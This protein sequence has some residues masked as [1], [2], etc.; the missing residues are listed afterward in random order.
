MQIKAALELVIPDLDTFALR[1]N[2]PLPPNYNFDAN[3]SPFTVIAPNGQE[4]L[5]QV[6]TVTRNAIGTPTIVQVLATCPRGSLVIGSKQQFLIVE[7]TQPRTVLQV[8]P[9][10]KNLIL[11]HGNLRLRASDVFGNKYEQSISFSKRAATPGR[12]RTLAVGPVS[13]TTEVARRLESTGSGT[14]LPYFGGFQAVITYQN[15]NT[16]VVSLELC[17]H[18]AMVPNPLADLYFTTLE[19]VMPNNWNAI[20]EWPEPFMDTSRI[21]GNDRILPLIKPLSNGNKHLL[22]QRDQ[23]EWRLYLYT[24]GQE[25]AANEVAQHKSWGVCVDGQQAGQRYWNWHNPITARYQTQNCIVPIVKVADLENRVKI[26]KDNLFLQLQNGLSYPDEGGGDGQLGYRNP[27]GVAYGGMTGGLGINEFDG[28]ATLSSRS[29][30]GLL[31]H[32]MLARRYGDRQRGGWIFDI[33]GIISLEKYLDADHSVPWSLYDFAFLAMSWPFQNQHNDRPFGFD[34]VDKT[35]VNFVNV[36]A[37]NPDYEV[38]ARA[39]VAID[40]QHF[41]RRSKDLRALI[42]LD[43]DYTAKRHLSA[44]CEILRMSY[45]EKPNGRLRGILDEVNGRLHKG[46]SWGRAEAHCLEACSTAFAI[47]NDKW[48]LRWQPWFDMAYDIIEKMQ[49]DNG[50]WL[51]LN[52]GKTITSFQFN[53][54]FSVLRP[55]EHEMMMHAVWGMGN[56]VYKGLASNKYANLINIF[57]KAGMAMWNIFWRWS[58]TQNRPDGNGPYDTVAIGPLD[59]HEPMFSTRRELPEVQYNVP[60]DNFHTATPLSY[61]LQEFLGLPSEDLLR[62]I[63][64]SYLNDSHLLA[65]LEY[66]GLDL[67]T[68]RAHLIGILQNGN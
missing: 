26:W 33:D 60:V 18:N 13:L 15:N 52:A 55:G 43:N 14:S 54:N 5:T 32:R 68:S 31:G 11:R 47:N 12:V 63:V 7:K 39:Y 9:D 1:G 61:G 24:P 20:S 64:A 3:T 37:L 44:H 40:S 22:Q 29:H 2:I 16:N 65:T 48:R 36:N 21:E 41:V 45:C 42:Y 62:S 51:R 57:N 34:D 49:G 56:A 35:Q 58:R 6:E 17:W 53:G 38:A 19:L 28:I 46:G 50:V 59:M 27:A 4:L 67:L 8:G 66:D 23:R 30:N 25:I 10:V